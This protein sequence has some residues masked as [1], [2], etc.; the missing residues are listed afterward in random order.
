M[1]IVF[2]KDN[3]EFVQTSSGQMPDIIKISVNSLIN[4]IVNRNT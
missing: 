2:Y 3:T 4:Q 1:W